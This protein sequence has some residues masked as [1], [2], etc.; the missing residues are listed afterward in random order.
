MLRLKAK[1]VR[2]KYCHKFFGMA[3]LKWAYENKNVT[4]AQQ[5]TGV[6]S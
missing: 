1:N 2:G 3:W 4:P 5:R 6:W